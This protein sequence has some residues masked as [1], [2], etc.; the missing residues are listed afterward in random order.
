MT[1]RDQFHALLAQRAYRQARAVLD[2]NPD[3]AYLKE[4]L[5]RVWSYDE[6]VTLADMKGE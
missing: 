5:F 6:H 3:L 2:A 4:L 1:A